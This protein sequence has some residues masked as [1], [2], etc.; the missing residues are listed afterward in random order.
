MEIYNINREN[1]F[2]TIDEGNAIGL[3]KLPVRGAA[4]DKA[5]LSLNIIN[6]IINLK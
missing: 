5:K 3:I 4:I 2:T 6:N 1:I